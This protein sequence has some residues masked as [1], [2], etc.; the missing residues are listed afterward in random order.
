MF[1]LRCRFP[2]DRDPRQLLRGVCDTLFD[3]N[4][5]MAAAEALG[6][7]CGKV[8]RRRRVELARHVDEEYFVRAD[9]VDIESR[10]NGGVDAARDADHNALHMDPSEEFLHGVTD[11]AVNGGNGCFCGTCSGR[12]E[13]CAV[14]DRQP[15]RRGGGDEDALACRIKYLCTAGKGVDCFS[16]VLQ[17]KGVNVENGH[18]FF[19]CRL[20]KCACTEAVREGGGIGGK[21]EISVRRRIE[22]G[23]K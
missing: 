10:C 18:V 19:A 15:F 7:L 13:L 2:H 14:G 3:W 6:K 20:R 17:P 11:R 21:D 4:D 16:L 12:R 23:I 5:H 9:G 8:L 22:E 1:A